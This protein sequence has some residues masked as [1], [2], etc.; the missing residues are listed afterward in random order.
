MTLRGLLVCKVCRTL[1]RAEQLS[2]VDELNS[3]V[4]QYEQDMQ[5]QF[6]YVERGKRTPEARQRRTI[7]HHAYK[8]MKWNMP[9]GQLN[10][11][12]TVEQRYW[13]DAKYRESMREIGWSD[14]TIGEMDDLYQA[15]Q[16]YDE[17]KEDER[18]QLEAWQR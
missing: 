18:A 10:P 12:Q 8:A 2:S 4:S 11:E 14:E 7:K 9:P 6:E 3:V 15:V 1:L 13:G 5:M 17:V 16:A